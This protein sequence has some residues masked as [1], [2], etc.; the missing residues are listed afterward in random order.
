M[1]ALP[2]VK[3]IL[4]LEALF[5]KMGLHLVKTNEKTI[6]KVIML[7]QR[8]FWQDLIEEAWKQKSIVWLMGVRRIGKTSLCQSLANVTYFDCELPRVRQLLDDPQGFLEGQR[9]KRL[10]L[11]EIHRLENPSELLKIAAD[12]YPDIKIIATGSS[13]LGTSKKFRD[14]LTGRKR[15]IWLTPLLLQELEVFGNTDINHRFLFGGLPSFFTQQQLPETDFQEWIDAYWAKD[16]QEIFSVA[17]RQPFQ[18]CAELLL[19]QSGGI[20]EA[21]KL[22]KFC[23][24]S[25]P[26]VLHYLTVL[27]ETFVVHIIRPYSSHKQTEIVKAP[28]IYGFDTGFVLHA[29]GKTEL[30]KEDRGLMWEL[31]VLNELNGQLQTR[32]INYWRDKQGHEIDFVLSGRTKGSPIALEC[33]FSLAQDS[34]AITKLVENFEAFRRHYPGEY[35]FVVASTIDMPFKRSYNGIPIHFIHPRE[36]AS[37]LR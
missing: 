28:K 36:L 24:V 11:D 32:A 19:A 29:Q 26:T 23:E 21:T 10:V 37:A 2:N 1:R 7:I 31:C 5:V 14:T 13:T 27:E 3:S 16:I 6:G 30:R 18:K 35:N 34:S 4:H 9:N 20:C 22:S 33:K 15:E 17:K 12:H 8:P 25:R